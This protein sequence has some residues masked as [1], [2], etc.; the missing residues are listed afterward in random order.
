MEGYQW[1][2]VTEF[3]EGE[4]AHHLIIFM[5]ANSS[6]CHLN[7]KPPHTLLDTN[8]K[9]LNVRFWGGELGPNTDVAET[10]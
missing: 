3:C 6:P 8:S 9:K 4:Y 1:Q 5:F 2:K 10:E 7:K